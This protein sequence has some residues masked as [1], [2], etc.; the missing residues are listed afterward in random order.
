LNRFAVEASRF[1]RAELRD[2]DRAL[3]LAAR[4]ADGLA[5]FA[6]QK[7]RQVLL[8]FLHQAGRA[9]DNATARRSGRASPLAKR[10]AR[11]LDRT[12][13]LF[14]RRLS[15]LAQHVIRIGRVAILYGFL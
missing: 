8:I 12:S 5:L 6:R 1:A 10:F 2:V 7:L 11:G 9:P 14:A 3:Q 15:Y 13:R 4:F